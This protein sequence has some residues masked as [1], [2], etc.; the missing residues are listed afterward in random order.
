MWIRYSCGLDV[1]CTCKKSSVHYMQTP[2]PIL[3]ITSHRHPAL[4]CLTIN[5][6]NSRSS[7]LILSI[8]ERVL[9]MAA[10]LQNRLWVK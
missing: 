4:H 1:R 7:G 2:G 5:K 3:S 9:A 10:D 8:F 6:K